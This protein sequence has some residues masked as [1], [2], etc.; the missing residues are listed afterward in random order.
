M[1]NLMLIARSDR[2]FIADPIH[3]EMNISLTIEG[4]D[5]AFFEI[6]S[7]INS[8]ANPSRVYSDIVHAVTIWA[9]L[10]NFILQSAP[11]PYSNT[12]HHKIYVGETGSG[13]LSNTEIAIEQLLG[14][15]G[16]STQIP[17]WSTDINGHH[18]SVLEQHLTNNEQAPA[19]AHDVI[20]A[21]RK[22]IEANKPMTPI[23]QGDIVKSMSKVLS[24]R[25]QSNPGNSHRD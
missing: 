21:K 5:D 24:H 16:E 1:S 15:Y 23:A 25:H 4:Y 6:Q 22:L 18:L 19:I 3:E 13:I 12:N 10:Q 9:E 17:S 8:R 20:L 14:L 11:I 7:K 2:L